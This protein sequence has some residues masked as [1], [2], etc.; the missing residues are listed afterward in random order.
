MKEIT[1]SEYENS[2]ADKCILVTSEG[3]TYFVEEN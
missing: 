2:N 1:K 3:T